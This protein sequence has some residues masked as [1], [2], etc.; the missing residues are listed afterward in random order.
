MKSFF[1]VSTYQDKKLET[2]DSPTQQIG[3]KRKETSTT[4]APIASTPIHVETVSP[5]DEIITLSFDPEFEELVTATTWPSSHPDNNVNQPTHISA[6][7]MPL[8]RSQ[9]N[10]SIPRT[11]TRSLMTPPHEFTHAQSI[12]SFETNTQPSTSPLY[13]LDGTPFTNSAEMHHVNGL[14][15]IITNGNVQFLY[16]ENALYTIYPMMV[17][18][19]QNWAPLELKDYTQVKE[20]YSRGDKKIIYS[21]PELLRNHSKQVLTATEYLQLEPTTKVAKCIATSRQIDALLFSQSSCGDTLRGNA[22]LVLIDGQPLPKNAVILNMFGVYCVIKP[23]R[24]HVIYDKNILN[25]SYTF[26][27]CNST[28]K[29]ILK[30]DELTMSIIENISMSGVTY[31][32]TLMR[33][34]LNP[35]KRKLHCLS[36]VEKHN[37]SGYP[38]T[39]AEIALYKKTETPTVVTTSVSTQ[40]TPLPLA[41]GSSI[42]NTPASDSAYASN[43]TVMPEL[44]EFSLFNQ[45]SNTPSTEVH[46]DMENVAPTSEHVITD[47]E[48]IELLGLQQ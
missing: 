4:T 36:K 11:S 8:A 37:Y 24:T 19:Q 39:M 46:T 38:R 22:S 40:V 33:E 45:T 25:S 7:A 1:T 30:N 42:L 26:Y 43:I 14:I 17:L 31:S 5:L 13:F 12:V 6:Q 20:S 41:E 9:P 28:L 47:E 16:T 35:I 44:F 34:K 18:Y 3:K 21:L 32:I 10:L 48:W 27:Y 23:G 29:K 15:Y 2:P